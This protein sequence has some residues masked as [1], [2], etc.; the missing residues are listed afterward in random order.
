M[1]ICPECLERVDDE[2]EYCPDDG[3]EL[4]EIHARTEDPMEGRVLEEKWVLESR[5][6]GG[7]MGN[8]YR[9]HQ[10]SVDRTV[11]VKILRSDLSADD[12]HVERF[13]R[14]AN[15]ASN[16]S[17]PRCVTIYDFGQS[18]RDHVLYLAMEYLEGASLQEHIDGSPL[19]FR[20][21]VDVGIEICK[22]LETLHDKGVV[23]RDLKPENVVLVDEIGEEVCLKLLDFGLAKVSSS[24]A[25]PVT[26]TGKVFGTPAFMS[27]EQ[28]MGSEVDLSSDIYSLGCMLYEFVAGRTPFTGDASV[29]ILLSHVNEVP[30]PIKAWAEVPA[31]FSKLLATM[32][33]KDP[34]DRPDSVGAVRA[35]L[36]S[37]RGRVTTGTAKAVPDPR[38]APTEGPMSAEQRKQLGV[39]QTQKYEATEHGAGPAA[40][41]PVNRAGDE[42][43][44]ELQKTKPFAAEASSSE[45]RDSTEGGPGVSAAEE[46]AGESEISGE[47]RRPIPVIWT[48]AAVIV[49]VGLVW[50]LLSERLA[51]DSRQVRPMADAATVAIGTVDAS[52][53]GAGLGADSGPTGD[54]LGG[55][56]G[57][58]GS[59]EVG[60]DVAGRDA[61]IDVGDE[62]AEEQGVAEPSSAG[63]RA[64]AETA[65]GSGGASGGTSS[66]EDSEAEQEP[67]EE[68]PLLPVLTQSAATQIFRSK[69]RRVQAC[70][71]RGLGTEGYEG[72]TVRLKLIVAGSGEV[73][74][75]SVIEETVGVDEVAD[76]IVEEAGDWSFPPT[77]N[78]SAAILK[79]AYTYAFDDLD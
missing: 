7:G 1:K 31:G 39:V 69:N 74:S 45:E 44:R 17:D 50:A 64:V 56:V 40:G 6:G 29:S 43:E 57:D 51:G 46:G 12:E 59:V 18:S 67:T 79:H 77:S 30:L 65:S 76:C 54:I 37:I 24:D 28:A 78:G 53:G 4:R 13:F 25:T 27:P 58:G 48:V 73:R 41:P 20:E 38:N 68:D 23:H 8:V 47:P 11:A 10:L 2:H 52:K 71:E 55:E 75:S 62:A 9:A 14:E 72:G 21:S 15:V 60:A 5:I 66:G 26:A 63:E 70:F 32:L 42:E 33:E 36:E 34:R 16:I 49:A 61:T 35:Q 3:T 22:A 19:T